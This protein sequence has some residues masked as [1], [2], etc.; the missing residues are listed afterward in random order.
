MP[1]KPVIMT[2]LA[3]AAF[4]PLAAQRVDPSEEIFRSG[5]EPVRIIDFAARPWLDSD[6]PTAIGIVGLPDYG[7]TQ[8]GANALSGD[9]RRAQQSGSI[10]AFGF[11]SDSYCSLP[12]IN[13]YGRFG[14]TQQWHRDRRWADNFDPYNGNP[15]LAG[16]DLAGDYSCQIFDFSVEAASHRL[17]QRVWLGVAFDYTV[18]DLSRSDDPR[19]RVQLA[20]Y[21]IRPGVTVA[22]SPHSKLGISGLYRHRKEKMLKPVAKAENIDKYTYYSMKGMAEYSTSSILFFSRRYTA[23][24]LGG[25]MQYEYSAGGFDLLARC[26]AVFRNEDVIGERKEQPGDYAE[27]LYEAALS[28]VWRSSRSLQRFDIAAGLG[29]GR[30]TEYMQEL[31][32]QT[33]AQGMID[34]YWQTMLQAVRYRNDSFSIDAAWRYYRLRPEGGYGWFIG[35]DFELSQSGSKYILPLSSMRIGTTEASLSGGIALCRRERWSLDINLEAGCRINLSGSMTRNPELAA[36]RK[37]IVQQQIVDP[38]FIVLTSDAIRFGG[39]I[40]CNFTL[41]RRTDCF[42]TIYAREYRRFAAPAAGRHIAGIALGILTDFKRKSSASLS[43]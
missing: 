22:I 21:A 29:R 37:T 33:N 18:G 16:S 40:V 8:A 24:Y 43:R 36:E 7:T 41:A 35:A 12:K 23:D 26:R 3:A 1:I 17:W 39:S 6:N 19:S 2:L 9:L 10:T 32:T 25:E 38:D 14:F 15:Y 20:D 28:G 13:L 4:V 11:S 27:N 5:I 34:T 30:A 42:V 31:I